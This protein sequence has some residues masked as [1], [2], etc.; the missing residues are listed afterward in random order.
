MHAEIADKKDEIARVCRRFDVEKLEVF[1]SAARGTDFDPNSS[2][3][4][5]LV[6]FRRDSNQNPFVR[7]FDLLDALRRALGREVDLVQLKSVSNPYLRESINRSREIVYE[8]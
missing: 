6:V 8:N 4:D 1:G 3:F 7:F 5:F 2:D